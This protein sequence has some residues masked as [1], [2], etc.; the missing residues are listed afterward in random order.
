MQKGGA[1]WCMRWAGPWGV[2]QV[3]G[4]VRR[5]CVRRAIDRIALFCQA[6]GSGELPMSKRVQQRAVLSYGHDE[7]LLFTRQQIIAAAG[8]PVFS[9]TNA[10]Q[11]R[12]MMRYLRPRVVLLCQSLPDAECARAVDLVH[13]SSPWSKVLVMSG[14]RRR[15]AEGRRVMVFAGDGP[16]A[17]LD[18]VRRLILGTPRAGAN[19]AGARSVLGLRMPTVRLGADRVHSG[20]L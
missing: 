5:G 6:D 18:T 20:Q 3:H 16:E 2:A 15:G 19:V 13:E 12:V 17:L 9:V 11:F 8:I 4:T 7:M 1:P 14:W 10:A